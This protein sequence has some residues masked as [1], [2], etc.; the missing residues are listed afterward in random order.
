MLQFLNRRSSHF[1]RTVAKNTYARYSMKVITVP[2]NSDNYGY[3]IVDESSNQCAIVDVS[4]QPAKIL[5]EVDKLDGCSLSAVF[6]THKHSDHAG[7]NNVIA[8]AFPGIA[9]Y[10]GIVDN[11]EGC[12]NY[13][14]D[15]DIINFGSCIQVH[16]L[17]TPGHTMGHISYFV[18]HNEQRVVF[19]GDTLFVGGAGKFFEGTGS[20]MYPSLYHKLAILP[21]DT[22][23]Y[24]GHEYT[25]S[26]Y[27]FALSIE[28]QNERLIEENNKA[29]AL[30]TQNLFTV[31]STIEKELAT[32]PFLRINE[33]TVKAKFAESGSPAELLT[34]LREAKNCF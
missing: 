16:C 22:L 5:S 8:K 21:P 1:L 33:P 18:T 19:T 7:G 31:P 27:R 3:L 23:V 9:I 30:R 11:V 17:H 26:N 20:D 2:L 14:Q 25:L 29:I 28:P 4:G 34:A 32:N 15:G 13:V 6:T 10:G 24:C 12:T